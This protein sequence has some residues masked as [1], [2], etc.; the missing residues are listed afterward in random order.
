[1]GTNFITN[2]QEVPHAR[3]TTNPK[4]YADKENL[5]FN[6]FSTESKMHGNGVRSI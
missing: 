3:M 1:M 5:Y 2:H 4:E 6:F